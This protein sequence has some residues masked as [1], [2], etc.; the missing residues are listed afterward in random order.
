V[1]ADDSDAA[2]WSRIRA[3]AVYEDEAAL[4]LNKPA[5]VSVMGER[6]GTDVVRLAEQAGETLYPVH[7]IDKTTSGAVLLARD[8]ARH[9]DLTRQFQR[10][11]VAKV[12]LAVTR[13]TGLPERGT[14]DL[15]LSVGRKNRVR[16]AGERGAITFDQDQSLWTLPDDARFGGGRSYPSVTRFTVLWSDE[17]H[18]VL[19]VSPVTGRRHQIRVHLAWIG[20]P[21]EGDPLY[22][23]TATAEGRRTALHS[24]RLSFDAAWAGGAR[25]AVPAPPGDDFW[26]PV[27]DRLPGG[28]PGVLARYPPG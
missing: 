20:H 5:G 28:P 21:V 8:L 9:G 17:R 6:H 26:A 22:D 12:Y 4:V 15:P 25:V 7:R 18:S 19:A 3:A 23:R 11:T 24:W 10:R 13:S 1:P 27:G 14:V 16:V 2:R